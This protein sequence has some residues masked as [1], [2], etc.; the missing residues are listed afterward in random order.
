MGL[1]R[2]RSAKGISKAT[3]TSSA[4]GLQSGWCSS[5]VAGNTTVIEKLL[6]PA[7]GAIDVGSNVAVAPAGSPETAKPIRFANCGPVGA[8]LNP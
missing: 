6:G 3:H 4:T 2:L 5:T 8:T 7:E 1:L